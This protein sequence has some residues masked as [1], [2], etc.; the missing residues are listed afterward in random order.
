MRA[1]GAGVRDITNLQSRQSAIARRSDLDVELH[2]CGASSMTS[3][4]AEFLF[5][6]VFQLDRFA[7]HCG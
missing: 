6:G 2:R 1:V 7:G 5:A 3:S 4:G